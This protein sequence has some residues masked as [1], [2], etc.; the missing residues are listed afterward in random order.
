MSF[1][2]DRVRLLALLK[3]TPSLSKEEFSKYWVETHA[4]LLLSVPIV[5]KNLLKYEQAHANDAIAQN[6]RQAGLP[7]SEWDGMA[8]FEAESYDKIM[9]VLRDPEYI[10]VVIPDGHN[11]LEWDKTVL[12][13]LDLATI[14]DN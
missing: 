14:F 2:Q 1:R 12:L 4:N 8:V 11:F 9:E 6:L 7:I 10:K 3:R 5:Q 13:P